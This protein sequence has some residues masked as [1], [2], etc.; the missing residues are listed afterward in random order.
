MENRIG[1]ALRNL[2]MQRNMSQET[3]AENLNVSRQAVSDWENGITQPDAAML[4]KISALFQVPLDA[5]LNGYSKDLIGKNRCGLAVCGMSI[6]LSLIHF[7][8]AIAGKVN[9]IGV[10]AS[11]LFASVVSLIMYAVFESSIKNNDFSMIAGYKKADSDHLPRF[12]RQLRTMSLFVGALALALNI[13]Y[14]PVYFADGSL[15]MRISMGYL[16]VFCLCVIKKQ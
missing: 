16:L 12:A 2:R 7:A 10:I 14:V 13:L 6:L 8:L 15:H 11:V 9:L 3:L 4:I 1:E 5:I